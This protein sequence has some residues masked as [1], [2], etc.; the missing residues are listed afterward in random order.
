M[1]EIMTAVNMSMIRTTLV[2]WPFGLLGRH[3]PG[4]W[5]ALMI[6]IS[7]HVTVPRREPI[8]S[9]FPEGFELLLT[10]HGAWE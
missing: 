5:D 8:S 1:V 10:V 4:Q 6:R 9:N 2:R 3:S 7:S